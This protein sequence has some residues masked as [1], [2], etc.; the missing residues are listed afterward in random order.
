M[1]NPAPKIDIMRSPLGRVRGRGA[2]RS[3]TA[4]WWAERITAAALVPLTLWFIFVMVSLLGAKQP[5]VAGFISHPFNAALL[6]ALI[7]V[8][9]QH[10][11]LGLQVVL[12]DYVPHPARRHLYVLAVQAGCVVLGLTAAVS[13]IKLAV[14]I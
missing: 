4:H 7:A 12:E 1:T 8:T 6:L 3:G 13:V 10:A 11:A 9:F 14:A 2:A 5:V